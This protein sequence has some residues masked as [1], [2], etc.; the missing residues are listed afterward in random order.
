[1]CSTL[2]CEHHSCTYPNTALNKHGPLNST[3][4]E[5]SL[6][7]SISSLSTVL[8]SIPRKNQKLYCLQAL[9]LLVQQRTTCPKNILYFATTSRWT[10]NQVNAFYEV[11]KQPAINLKNVNY[12]WAM[13]QVNSL[14][15][16]AVS[17]SCKH[18]EDGISKIW[19]WSEGQDASKDEWKN[20]LALAQSG[21]VG[22]LSN[23]ELGCID[24]AILSY[25]TIC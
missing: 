25:I 5:S 12:K 20:R 17:Q 14:V 6:N 22:N 8:D 21:L 9:L 2:V 4:M 1:M 15:E 13:E 16:G 7:S 3:S 23:E 11:N 18:H 19:I 10:P 24:D